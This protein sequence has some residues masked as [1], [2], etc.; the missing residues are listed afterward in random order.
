M[1][2]LKKAV[3]A[4]LDE[5]VG[6]AALKFEDLPQKAEYVSFDIFDT[7]V[8]RDIN[9]PSELFSLIE[10][11]SGIED[12][13]QKRITAEQAAREKKHGGEVTLCEIYRCFPGIAPDEADKYC[14]RELEAELSVCRPNPAMIGFYRKCVKNKK[15]VLISDMYLT[16]DMMRRI[17]DKCGITGYE[18]LYISCDTGVSKRGGGL[19]RHVLSNLG[20]KPDDM[21]H[22]GNDIMSDALK[23]RKENISCRKLRTREN[24]LLAGKAAKLKAESDRQFSEIYNFINNTTLS[25]KRFKSFYYRFGYENFGILLFGFCNWIAKEAE[26][27]GIEQMLF[28]A[29]DG[30]IIKKA[31]DLMGLSEKIPSYYFEMSRRSIRVPA[32]FSVPQS[33]EKALDIMALPSRI[34]MYQLFEY[35]GLEPAEHTDILKAADIGGDEVF[36]SK[37]LAQNKR[38]RKVYEALGGKIIQNAVSEKKVLFEYLEKFGF[39]SRKTAVVDIG[40]GAT[41]Q[42][43]L[44]KLF[45]ANGINADI[46]GYYIFLDR[47]AGENTESVTLKAHGYVWDNYN[48]HDTKYEEQPFV[49]LFETLF[50]EQNGSVKRYIRTENGASAE[51]YEY[52]FLT[53][54]GEADEISCIREVQ[55]G[56]LDLIGRING[57]LPKEYKELCG[58]DAFFLMRCCMTRPSENILKHFYNFRFFNAGVSSFLA[59]PKYSLTGYML[60][61]RQLKRDF[62]AAE[63]KMGFFKYLLKI[64]MSYETLW[65]ILKVF[66]PSPKK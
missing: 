18:K 5:N 60:R 10:K 66:F 54:G 12:F 33:Y 61:P 59:K 30:Y 13:A 26:K 50:F 3:K 57:N 9:K 23:A 28:V 36:W 16:G 21:I 51:R 40:Y 14:R 56:A 22:I 15:V 53:A 44:L 58:N 62:Y 48:R 63:W 37:D 20:I 31:Y 55:N 34:S 65:K 25:N 45:A 43:E 38:V 47:K 4:F 6:A 24:R 46:T 41:I 39:D 64:D 32:S 35:W 29:R 11:S 2:K 7:L 19:Y 42:K 49:G 27:Q 8:V 1:G 17:L 52:E